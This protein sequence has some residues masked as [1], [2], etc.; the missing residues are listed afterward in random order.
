MTHSGFWQKMGRLHSATGNGCHLGGKPGIGELAFLFY[1]VCFLFAPFS[2]SF[3]S[4]FRNNQ[5]GL[6]VSSGYPA[7]I[8]HRSSFSHTSESWKSKVRVAAWSAS[9][10]SP[11]PG[12]Q[13]A[14]FPLCPHRGSGGTSLV[15]HIRTRILSQGSHP[16][17][18]I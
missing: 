3:F 15:S 13:V 10:D 18:F 8:P 9:G 6:L 14:A 4:L 16:R 11:F 1:F 2:L 7:K 5:T 12:L 17:D